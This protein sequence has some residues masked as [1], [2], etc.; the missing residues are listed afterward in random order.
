MA[1]PALSRRTLLRGTGL[2]GLGV[3]LAACGGGE[4][5]P[6]TTAPGGTDLPVDGGDVSSA[7]LEAA[8]V[9]DGENVLTPIVA[10]FEVLTGPTGRVQFGLLDAENTPL[11]DAEVQVWIVGGEGTEVVAGPLEPIF[12]G[13]GLGTRGV[14]VLEPALETAGL[15]DLVVAT[16]GGARVGTAALRVIAPEES[17]VVRPGQ[18]FPSFATPTTADPMGLE[19]L[20]TRTPPCGM[21]ELSLDEALAMGKPVVLTVSTP[22]YCQTAVCG[23]VVD[24]VLAAKEARADQEVLFIHAE[25]FTDAGNTPTDYVAEDLAL[26]T[27]PWTWVIGADGVVTDRFDGPVVAPLLEQALDAL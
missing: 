14:Y 2:A 5:D 7:A 18:E 17:A 24:V 25:V 6:G 11:L 12:Y 19:E 26:P 3:V 1:I 20:C 15:L 21:H 8:G 27:E 9:A 16:D 23:P 13:E 10:T 4:T 22:K